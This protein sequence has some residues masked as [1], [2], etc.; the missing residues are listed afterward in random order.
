MH[1]TAKERR[2]QCVRMS[3]TERISMHSS[4]KRLHREESARRALAE[5]TRQLGKGKLG[6]KCNVTAC[7]V[8]GADVKW[9]N[10]PMHAHYCSYCKREIS[11][12]DD[13]VGTDQAIFETTPRTVPDAPT[14]DGQN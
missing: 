2:L 9:W 6:G 1:L 10:R 3:P 13:Y 11:R 8:R 14:N 5:A 4:N 7:N 12:F